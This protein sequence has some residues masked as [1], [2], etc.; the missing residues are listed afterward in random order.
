MVTHYLVETKDKCS[1][2]TDTV[3]PHT[4]GKNKKEKQRPYLRDK[5]TGTGK[6]A[7]SR[8]DK[9]NGGH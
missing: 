1:I 2:Q 4:V 3:T 9:L 7:L 6:F 5:N 8:Y